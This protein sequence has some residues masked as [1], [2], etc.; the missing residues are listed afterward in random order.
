ML[1]DENV[2]CKIVGQEWKGTASAG[3]RKT[4]RRCGG[5]WLAGWLMDG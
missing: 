1:V 5:R 3:G 4:E 2:G